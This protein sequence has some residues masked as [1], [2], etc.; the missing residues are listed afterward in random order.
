[1]VF[2][3]FHL[4]HLKLHKNIVTS[5]EINARKNKHVHTQITVFKV[6]STLCLELPINPIFI[7]V[8]HVTSLH[9]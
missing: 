1:M 6:N 2:I 8:T 3:S 4:G 5:K 9:I 7:N